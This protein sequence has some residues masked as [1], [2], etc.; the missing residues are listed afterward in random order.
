MY[1]NTPLNWEYFYTS[2]GIQVFNMLMDR[3]ICKEEIT[4]S[5]TYFLT[6]C[7]STVYNIFWYR[8]R[9]II[10]SKLQF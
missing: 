1:K 8:Y 2:A 10:R 3:R 7:T 9:R 5:S 4:A 6:N